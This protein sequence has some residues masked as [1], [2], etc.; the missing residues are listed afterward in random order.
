M[1]PRVVQVCEKNPITGEV[2]C[3]DKEIDDGEPDGNL[4]EENEY[5]N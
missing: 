1:R 2:R 5:D 4:E 3:Y